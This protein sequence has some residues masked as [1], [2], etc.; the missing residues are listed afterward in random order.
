MLFLFFSLYPNISECT[1]KCTCMFFFSLYPNIFECTNNCTCMLF[2]F[3]LLSHCCK[4]PREYIY[5]YLYCATFCFLLYII[6]GIYCII[7]WFYTKYRY[8]TTI[9]SVLSGHSKRRPKIGF[10]D[11]LS[12]NAGQKCCRMLQG[13]HSAILSTFIKLPLRSLFC[14]FLSGRLRQVLLYMYIIPSTV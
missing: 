3:I 14:L 11:R 7:F 4:P 10:Q 13:E 2:L 1:D 12:L 8:T 6:S 5:F 9:K